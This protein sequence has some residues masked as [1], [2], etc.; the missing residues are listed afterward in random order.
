MSTADSAPLDW[1]PQRRTPRASDDALSGTARRW[2]RELPS[3]RRP[4]RLCQLFPR[5]ANRLAWCWRDADLAT[6]VLEDLLQDRRGSRRGF[7]PS[8]VR[9]LQRLAQFNTQQRVDPQG[10][11]WWTSFGKLAGLG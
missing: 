9:E 8:V 11:G 7:P 6:Q 1:T 5:V 2:L 3:R 4:I 10:D